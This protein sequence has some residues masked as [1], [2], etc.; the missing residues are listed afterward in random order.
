MA[1]EDLTPFGTAPKFYEGLLGAEETAALQKRAQVQGLLGAGLAL[2]QGMSRGGAPRSALQNILGSVVG[3][4]QAAGG[5]YEGGLRNYQTQQQIQQ[6]RIAQEQ[7]K[8]AQEQA[9]ALRSDVE[10]V[11]RTPEV[12]NNPSLVAL[13]RADPKEGLKWINENMAVSQAYAPQQVSAPRLDG[14][15][16]IL[17]EVETVAPLDKRGMLNQA[18]DRLEGK[19]GEGSR[20]ER[21]LILKRLENLDK[22]EEKER[23]L[24]DFTNEDIRVANYLFPDRDPYKPLTGEQNKQV[25]NELQRLKNER[26]RSGATTINMPSE[27]ERTAGYLTTRLQNSLQQYQRVLGEDPN[28]A[29]PNLRAEIVKGV[30]RSDY[31]KNLVN[32]ESRQRVEAAQLDML[33]AA[34]TMATGAAYTREQL[35]STRGTYFPSLG[36]KPQTVKDKAVRLDKLLK[37]AAMTK[38]GRAAPAPLPSGSSL[39]NID[40][41]A[42][43]QELEKRKK[44]GK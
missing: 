44:E 3:G 2:A 9:I 43:I 14:A 15:E 42:I 31:L 38:A 25:S 17:P 19:T 20:K 35:E 27:S 39:M 5:A 36:D 10:A 26:A 28:A 11:M 33:D 7:A 13:L 12:A 29:L 6:A 34:L 32:P 23:K 22:Q 21:E 8:M 1:I 16:K 4:F 37:E 24:T 41:N 18:L 40:T 30:S